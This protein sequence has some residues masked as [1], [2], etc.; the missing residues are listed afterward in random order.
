MLVLLLLA[1]LSLLTMSDPSSDEDPRLAEHSQGPTVHRSTRLAIQTYPPITEW[2]IEKI[3]ATLYGR[4]IQAPLGINHNQLFH[5]FLENIPELTPTQSTPPSGPK[6]ATAKRKHCSH[7]NN[8]QA[9]KKR[10]DRPDLTSPIQDDSMMS[11]LQNILLSISNL[12]SR[13]QALE[14]QPSS[15]PNVA[16]ASLNPTPL[17]PDAPASS[18]PA[19]TGLNLLP[20]GTLATA[21][22]AP[23]ALSDLAM[24]YGGN[25]F[26]EYHKSFS[27][28]SATFIHRF[29]QRLDWS[30]VDLALI[31]RHFTG[32]CVLSSSLCG[33][34]THTPSL[35]PRSAKPTTSAERLLKAND[36]E[37]V[38]PMIHTPM[39]YNFNENVCRFPNCKFIHACSYCGD[40]HPKSVC[41]RRMRAPS[42]K[43]KESQR[44]S[45]F[46]NLTKL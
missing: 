39:C 12:D 23:V 28:K 41:P 31:S 9:T 6:K 25:L 10:T 30:A 38:K 5:F 29:N 36:E 22:P 42:K 14:N 2:P 3:L 45:T 17:V 8:P 32:H 26:Y 11:A 16:S 44:L 40:G 43:R 15:I 19:N 33:A 13:I 1:S 46:P 35:C 34:F 20:R 21:L 27:A 37:K 4:N 24:T 18:T 7:A